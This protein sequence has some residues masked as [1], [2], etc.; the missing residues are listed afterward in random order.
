MMIETNP[1]GDCQDAEF[2]LDSAVAPSSG[3]FDSAKWRRHLVIQ[4]GSCLDFQE[5]KLSEKPQW[6]KCRWVSQPEWVRMAG[7]TVDLTDA[8]SRYFYDWTLEKDPFRITHRVIAHPYGKCSFF[9]LATQRTHLE[10]WY[11]LIAQWLNVKA[12]CLPFSL[13]QFFEVNPVFSALTIHRRL[14]TL[15]QSTK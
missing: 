3:R 2:A 1:W 5:E 8:L 11:S 7:L 15:I 4:N 6:K 13:V 12:S 10:K 14:R 9:L